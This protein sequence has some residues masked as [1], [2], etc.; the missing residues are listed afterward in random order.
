MDDFDCGHPELDEWLRLH[1]RH[2]T[3]QETRTYLLVHDSSQQIVGYF[4]LAPI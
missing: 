2:A 1:A 3:A 4:A